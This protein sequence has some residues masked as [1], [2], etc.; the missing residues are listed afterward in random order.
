MKWIGLLGLALTISGGVQSQEYFQQHVAYDIHVK[1]DDQAYV[2]RASEEIVYTNNSPDTLTFLYFHLWPNAY[3]N[4]K[5]ALAKQLIRMGNTSLAFA[6]QE[7]LGYIDSLAFTL[8][9]KPC[10]WEFD[11]EHI[12]ICKILLERPLLPGQQVT[13]ATPFKVKLPSGHISRLG[14]LGQTFQI[15]QWYPKPAVYDT[16]GWHPM[17][18]LT[19]GEFY[20]EFGSFD[21]HIE[22]P[23]NYTVGAT[24]DLQTQSEIDRLERLAQETETWIDARKQNDDWQDYREEMACPASSESFKTLHYHQEKV[25]DFAWFADKR[26]HVLKGEVEL[27]HTGN[28]CTLWTMFT[29]RQARL[30]AES[31]EYMHDAVYYYSLWNGDYPYAHATAVDGT[32]SAGGGMEYPNVTV[33]G[34]AQSPLSLETVIMHEVG[35]NWFYGILGSNERDHAWLDEGIN[36]YNEQRYLSTK[37][38]N[39]G[40]YS[41]SPPEGFTRFIGLHHY[42]LKDQHYFVHMLRA[43]PNRDQPL[44]IR[45]DLYSDLNYG[46][47]VYSKSAVFLNYLRHYLGDSVMDSAMHFYF[48]ENKFKHPAPQSFEYA[49]EYTSGQDLDWFFKDVITTTGKLDYGIQK[50]KVRDGQ[51]TVRLKNSGELNSPVHIA[52][53]DGDRVVEEKWVNGFAKDS[54]LT[55]AATADRVQ[56][57]PEKVMPEVRRENNYARSKGLLKRTEPVQ[58]KLMG[59]AERP[60]LNSLYYMPVFGINVPNG[61]MPGLLLYNSS[62]PNKRFSYYLLPMFSTRGLKP[63][64]LGSVAYSIMPS[65]SVFESIELGVHG[66]RYMERYE[67]GQDHIYNRVI[68]YATFYLRPPA[69]NGLFSHEFTVSSISILNQVPVFNTDGSVERDLISKT[70]NRFDYD[71]EIDHPVYRTTGKWRLEEHNQ[72]QGFFRTSLELRE[73]INIKGR[74]RTSFRVFAGTFLLNQSTDPAYNWRMDGQ[75]Y[76]TDYAYDGEVLDRTGTSDL[77]SRQMMETH[78]AIK[79]PTAWGQ[80]NR[81]LMAINWKAKPTRLPIGVFADV[82][83]NHSSDFV[84]DAGLY[85]AIIPDIVEV[86]VPLAYTSNVRKEINANGF[87]FHELIRFQFDVDRINPIKYI[88]RVEIP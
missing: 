51:T 53:M 78:G 30:W 15:T 71:F 5:T 68:P 35:H 24:G 77:L 39:G 46:V 29:N 26:F 20:S 57:D 80:S 82:G 31:I 56:I 34:S 10:V 88:R 19:Q 45:S 16:A 33:I 55:F 1:L 60:D 85:A 7:D 9:G 63:V 42:G 72:D 28:T 75:S 86:Y 25:H 32:I 66:K 87:K 73:V 49:I 18:Y 22:L 13:V 84:A 54:T 58:L 40:L 37:Y 70:Y 47:I 21:V 17:P 59:A 38:P 79:V 44:N 12:D 2:L 48:D 23:E 3:R 41:T 14:H 4:H 6:P 81:W 74:V 8:D 27:P 67:Q 50:V 64:G 36:S 43:R 62:I 52:L 61:F 83:I 65:K 76:R 11:E 69:Y